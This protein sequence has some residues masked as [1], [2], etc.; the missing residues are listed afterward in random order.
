MKNNFLIPA[1]IL[2][3]INCSPSFA[4]D[5]LKSTI[6]SQKSVEVTV[7]ND[8]LGL[9]KDTR[10]LSL[11]A[12]RG[13][14]RFEDV[15]AGIMPVTVHIKPLNNQDSFEIL[16]QNYE[17]DLMNSNKLLDKYVGKN[18]KLIDYN[19]YQD[20]K[21]TFDAIL[22]SNNNGDP[23][24]KIGDEIY[25]GHPGYRVLPQIPENLIARPTLMWIYQT[26]KAQNYDVQVSYLTSGINWKADYVLVLNDRDTQADLSGWV[27]IDNRSGAMYKDAKLK[28]V[29]GQV[30]RAQNQFD[31][32]ARKG[33]VAEAMPAVAG[34]PQ[35]QENAFFEYHIYD[36]QRPATIKDNQTKQISLLE[37]QNVAVKKEL[38]VESA[39]GYFYGNYMGQKLKNPVQVYVKFK[40]SESN[41]MGMPLP[42]GTMRFYK[43]DHTG[44]LQ[45]IGE[46]QIE[47]TPKDEEV[48][49]KLGEA[50]DVVCERV[51][52]DYRIIN[53]N[54]YETE[55]ELTLRNHKKEDVIVT[56]TEP[57][58]DYAD[59]KILN[60][61]HPY[62]E[63]DAFHIKFDVP[64]PKDQ[65]VKLKYRVYARVR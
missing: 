49:L 28:L 30:N 57:I 51:Q 10:K 53:T 44:S 35:F 13:E 23:I 11:A 12:G 41:H 29:A 64:V 50:F 24:Y 19:P 6:D 43:Q 36:L 55:W 46:D 60:S 22:L 40:N 62:Q 56:V 4:Q 17:Y 25:L 3:V 38:E 14:L 1:V 9:I 58:N 20:K 2:L 48:K 47:H 8:D 18:L 26:A 5:V 39:A 7:Y 27:T 65:E 61:S 37:A 31:M 15:A 16:E 59:W 32:L 42:K 34:A 45:F 33:M 54:V 21:E 52:K 63:V